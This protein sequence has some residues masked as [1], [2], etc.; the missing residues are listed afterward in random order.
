M[1]LQD[2][3]NMCKTDV[4]K[5]W[6]NKGFQKDISSQKGTTLKNFNSP[7]FINLFR[8]FFEVRIF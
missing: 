1:L 2:L 6:L 5:I 3:C 4:I 7:N 8:I